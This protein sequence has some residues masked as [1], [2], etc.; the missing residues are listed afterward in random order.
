MPMSSPQ[1]TRMLGLSVGMCDPSL[2][3]GQE[4]FELL[5][6]LVDAETGWLVARRELLERVE[7]LRRHRRRVEHEEV[8]P[9]EP[10][11]VGV[12]RDVGVFVRVGA[13]VEQLG[14]PQWGE[15]LGPDAQR[16]LAP[17][18]GEY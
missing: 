17:L 7:E 5:D 10:V 4:F 12:G 13:Q 11:V 3:A 6:D 14:H 18:F 1:M 9:D 16:A 15:R 2:V 8:A